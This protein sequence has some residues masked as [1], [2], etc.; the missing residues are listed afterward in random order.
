MRMTQH[1]PANVL[2]EPSFQKLPVA[3]AR[4]PVCKVEA[5]LVDRQAFNALQHYQMITI[6]C[7]TQDC[8]PFQVARRMVRL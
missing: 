2:V 6:K 4:C 8:P 7:Q 1:L 5:V 3:V